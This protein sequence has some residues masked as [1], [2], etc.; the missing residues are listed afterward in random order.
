MGSRGPTQLLARRVLASW[1]NG[2]FGRLG[3]GSPCLSE[4][5]PRV[6]NGLAEQEVVQVACGGAHTAI[7][8]GT[9]NA[10]AV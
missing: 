9:A 8:T 4:L 5:K 10:C 1:G 3:H 6:I 7:V 2:D